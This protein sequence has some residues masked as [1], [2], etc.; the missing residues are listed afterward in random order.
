MTTIAERLKAWRVALGMTQDKFA[1]HAGIPKRTLVG[2]ENAERE[3]GTAALAAIAKTGVNMTWL[4][5]GD[6][7]MMDVLNEKQQDASLPV[8][9]GK[10]ARR[11]AKI[12]ELVESAPSPE[13][14]EALMTELFS[15]AQ[16]AAELAALKKT[17]AELQA[18]V[19][20]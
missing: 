9:A 1:A 15:R 3:P 7:E 20:A 4:L 18:Q 8:L 19:R 2:Y 11:W 10:H 17:V 16:Q 12:I 6:G 5:T 14:T 13:K